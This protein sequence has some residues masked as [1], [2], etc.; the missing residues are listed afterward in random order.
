MTKKTATFTRSERN[1]LI[2]E[3]K[4]LKKEGWTQAEIAKKHKVSTAT[5]SKWLRGEVKMRKSR[6]TPTKKAVPTRSTGA[7]K[8]L[9]AMVKILKVDLPA[10]DRIAL[11]LM[12]VGE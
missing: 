9:D 3:A 5:M 11:A 4:A 8:K 1:V 10:E 2:K 12:T 7:A 6:K